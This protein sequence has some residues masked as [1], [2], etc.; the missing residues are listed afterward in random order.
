MTD[1]GEDTHRVEKPNLPRCPECNTVVSPFQTNC[2]RCGCPITSSQ[3]TTAS[4][5]AD[6]APTPWPVEPQG[7]NVLKPHASVI[8]QFLPSGICVTLPLHKPLILGR[9]LILDVE[10]DVLDLSTFNATQHGVSRHHCQLYRR[11]VQLVVTDLGST[12]GTYLN[13]EELV[14]HRDYVVAHTDKLIIGTLHLI[15]SFSAL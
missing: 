3:Q 12:N 2:D 14:S 11:G 8:L 5:P 10:E 6:R 9:E 4:R 7:H 15:V 1:Q 13:G